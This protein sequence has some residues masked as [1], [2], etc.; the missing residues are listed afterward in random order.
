MLIR[1]AMANNK[2]HLFFLRAGFEDRAIGLTVS[3]S[4][5]LAN[6]RVAD[7]LV[8]PKDNERIDPRR[9]PSWEVKRGER[10]GRE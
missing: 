1:Y 9:T 4:P 7:E 3:Y 10:H 6:F 5:F 8:C 2:T